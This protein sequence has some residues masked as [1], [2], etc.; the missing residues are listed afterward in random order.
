MKDRA[1]SRTN[2]IA[3]ERGHKTRSSFNQ[4]N[5]IYLIRHFGP[6]YLVAK[7][8]LETLAAHGN[9]IYPASIFI[10]KNHYIN[11]ERLVFS[12]FVLERPVHNPNAG[13]YNIRADNFTHDHTYS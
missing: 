10:L 8:Y 3:K 12:H 7:S 9:N 4:Q 11:T 5:G 2:I 1:W 6:Y 13:F